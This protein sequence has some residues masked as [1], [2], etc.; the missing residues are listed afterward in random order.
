M[1]YVWLILIFG[2]PA[3]FFV[4]AFVIGCVEKHP[5][6]VFERAQLDS[7]PAYATEMVQRSAAY[8]FQYRDSGVHPKFGEKVKG[9]LMLSDDGRILAVIGEG[10]IAGMKVKKTLLFSTF[11]DG[12]VLITVDEAGTSE[13]D[14]RTTRQ[15][16]MNADFEEL[17]AKH[18]EALGRLGAGVATF[19]SHASWK[20]LDDLNRKRVDR[21]VGAG[22]ARYVDAR[23]EEYRFTVW[24]AFKMTILHGIGQVLYPPNY[25]RHLKRRPG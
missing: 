2:I 18:R 23:R 15:I 13:M 8:G 21:I 4:A 25:W 20:D 1:G 7:L 16:F 11:V 17:L 5:V 10:T 6:P 14:P 3:L 22:L 9:M 19:A 24:A 12:S